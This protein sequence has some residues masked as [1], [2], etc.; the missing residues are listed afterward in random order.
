MIQMCGARKMSPRKVRPDLT[1]ASGLRWAFFMCYSCACA[2]V[3]DRCSAVFTTGSHG[4]VTSSCYKMADSDINRI[5]MDSTIRM[6]FDVGGHG[7]AVSLFFQLTHL[8]GSLRPFCGGSCTS[9]NK[10]ARWSTASP[11]GPFVGPC[12]LEPSNTGSG[13]LDR[14]GNLYWMMFRARSVNDDRCHDAA[15]S[16][17][18]HKTNSPIGLDNRFGSSFWPITGLSDSIKVYARTS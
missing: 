14:N 15:P 2:L 13:S 10:I 7:G 6:D 1:D 12:S 18:M 8:D 16:A 4:S 5:M 17:Q 11:F 9:V 3:C